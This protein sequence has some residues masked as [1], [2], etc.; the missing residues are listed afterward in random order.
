MEGVARAR[1]GAARQLSV[2]ADH[3][4]LPYRGGEPCATRLHGCQCRCLSEEA[5]RLVPAKIYAATAEASRDPSVCLS[6][7]AGCKT[8]DLAL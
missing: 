4:H 5:E 3:L 8:I 1:D 7:F 2:T 6:K